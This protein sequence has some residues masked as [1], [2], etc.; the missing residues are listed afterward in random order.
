MFLFRCVSLY[1]V[2]TGENLSQV[3]GIEECSRTGLDVEVPEEGVPSRLR[4]SRCC[5]AYCRVGFDVVVIRSVPF[6]LVLT[7]FDGPT[8]LLWLLK[9]L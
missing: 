9:R 8:P 2:Q 5:G 7:S 6:R 3:H 1:D 4:K